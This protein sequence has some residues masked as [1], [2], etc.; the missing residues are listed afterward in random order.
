[1][2]NLSGKILPIFMLLSSILLLYI[3]VPRFLAELMLVPGTPIYERTNLG[4]QVS[5]EELDVL[6][7]SREQAIS[8]VDHPKAYHQLGLVF[9][10]RAQR[11]ENASE[12]IMHAET[13]IDKLNTSLQL[14]PVN[15]FAWA[16]LATAYMLVGPENNDKAVEAWRTSVALARFEPFLFL[17]RNHI[18][19]SLY[20]NLN[21]EDREKLK[22]QIDLTY[23]WNRGQLRSY[24]RQY[25]LV[26]W[27]AFLLHGQ[28]E[29]VE[30][31][32]AK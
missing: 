15:T 25:D 13:A 28:L 27:V 22:E 8:F 20:N 1:M 18:G 12:R 2:K 26:N 5:D 7:E 31:I 23:D 32:R 14:A 6:Q 16:R 9:L 19:I 21:E 17:S 29:K 24:A 4:E 11:A 10:L 30:W 3:G